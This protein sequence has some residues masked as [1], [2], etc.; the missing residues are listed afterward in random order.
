M[1][2]SFEMLFSL[3]F[4]K[5]LVKGVVKVFRSK[6]VFISCK[7]S[8]SVSVSRIESKNCERRF[9]L[10]LIADYRDDYGGDTKN[11]SLV[12]YIEK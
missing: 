4:C 11:L 5:V 10:V 7:F 8:V 3:R 1:S 6:S 9:F 12:S 2:S